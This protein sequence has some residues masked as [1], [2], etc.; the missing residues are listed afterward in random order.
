MMSGYCRSIGG[1]VGLGLGAVA[2]ERERLGE[3]ARRWVTRAAAKSAEV[4]A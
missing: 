4:V 2:E 3:R 1:A